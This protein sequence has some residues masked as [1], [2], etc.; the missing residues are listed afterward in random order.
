MK[1]LLIGV[2]LALIAS[3]A[4]S[5]T[6]MP[7]AAPATPPLSASAND[8]PSKMQKI[9]QNLPIWLSQ[10]PDQQDSIR[11]LMQKIDGHL[12]ASASNISEA[13]KIAD[14]ILGIVGQ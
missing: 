6:P 9:Q 8:L 3:D 14:K 11:S 13:E 5:Q 10:H 2:V 1:T 7:G 12:R 4:M